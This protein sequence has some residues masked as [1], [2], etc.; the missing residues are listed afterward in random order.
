M[1]SAQPNRQWGPIL[2]AI[3][4]VGAVCYV[5]AASNGWYPAHERALGIHSVTGEP[6]VW[7]L[8]VFPI[9]VVFILLN[10]IWSAFTVARQ[11]WRRGIWLLM[12]IPVWLIAMAIDY[13][14]H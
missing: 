8:V 1:N 12:T 7:A 9:W 11:Q 3:N 5:I 6:Y 2:L 10:L 4:L 14:H 13:A